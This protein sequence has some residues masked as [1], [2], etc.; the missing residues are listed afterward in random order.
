MIKVNNIKTRFLGN[1]DYTS[2]WNKMKNFTYTR[3][4]E[5]D[6]ELWV[7]EH[8]PIYTLGNNVKSVRINKSS[9]IPLLRV[10]R[11]GDI[12]YHAPGQIM[13][14]ALINIRRIGMSV[15]N[16]I[17][18][19]EDAVI[20]LMKKFD[21]KASRKKGAPGVYVKGEKIASI[22]L[23]I[24][25]GSSYHGLSLNY[26]VDLKPF[27]DIDICGYHDLKATSLKSLKIRI[28]KKIVAESL[29]DLINEKITTFQI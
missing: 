25:R 17:F 8:F 14:Y 20:S 13:I 19:L 24:T 21:V 2:V 22:G 27:S 15:S 3:D 23:R 7:T 5:T 12:T 9:N 16:L 10:D 6:D 4:D 11:G 18:I 1:S 28:N 26:D 29:V